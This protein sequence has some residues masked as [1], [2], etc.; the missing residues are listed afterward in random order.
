MI[1]HYSGL[2]GRHDDVY[3]C[4]SNHLMPTHM[5]RVETASGQFH[6]A[7]RA[8]ALLAIGGIVRI[9]KWHFKCH[10]RRAE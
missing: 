2:G 1:P 9:F 8:P 4:C 10:Y 5:Q 3:I 6:T 7:L